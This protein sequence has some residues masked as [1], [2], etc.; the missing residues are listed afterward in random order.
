[1]T[2][3]PQFS[4]DKPLTVAEAATERDKAAAELSNADRAL[5]TETIL[6][7]HALARFQS[8]D[9]ALTAAYLATRQKKGPRK[10][11]AVETKP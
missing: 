8:A 3:E 4:P 1:M 11:K 2:N 6:H 9:R 7:K 5:E 10:P